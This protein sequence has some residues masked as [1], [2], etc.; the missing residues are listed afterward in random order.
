MG[1]PEISNPLMSWMGFL[2]GSDGKESAYNARDWHSTPG[3]G[4]PPG[5]GHGNS[6]QYSGLENPIDRG[7]WGIQSAGSQRVR[8]D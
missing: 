4:R 1:L 2:P 8:P 7:A 3:L 5:G 6:L